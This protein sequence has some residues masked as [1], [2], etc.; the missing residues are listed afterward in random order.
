MIYL[1]RASYISVMP[2]MKIYFLRSL[3]TEKVFKYFSGDMGEGG[4]VVYNE[5]RD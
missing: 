1:I 2:N 5:K 3:I 4:G